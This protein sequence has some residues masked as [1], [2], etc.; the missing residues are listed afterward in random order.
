MT[1]M[2]DKPR[3]FDGKLKPYPHEEFGV[4]VGKFDFTVLGLHSLFI[5]MYD[6]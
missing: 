5:R 2:Y 3:K 6:I 4:E 1:D